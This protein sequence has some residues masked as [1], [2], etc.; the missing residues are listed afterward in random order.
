MVSPEPG[1]DPEQEALLGDS[2]GLALFVV[3]DTLSPAERLAF[4]LHDV[5]AVPFDDIAP[6]VGRPPAATR[7]LASRARRR[8]QGAP[9]PDADLATSGTSS[10][11]SSPPPATATSSGCWRSWTR[12]GAAR[13]G[14]RAPPESGRGDPR[15]DGCRRHAP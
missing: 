4:V 8:V 11:P 9:V 12:R 15:R 3:L 7:Q 6:I 2:V 5:F 13:D 10:T 1:S 14:G